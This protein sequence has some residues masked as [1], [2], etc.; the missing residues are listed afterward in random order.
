MNATEFEI[1]CE[2]DE[3]A[4]TGLWKRWPPASDAVSIARY[5]ELQIQ[6]NYRNIASDTV[7]AMLQDLKV[8]SPLATG[9]MTRVRV[10]AS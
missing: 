3:D 7:G 10:P 8:P 6:F 1:T 5:S 9:I 4:I 2:V